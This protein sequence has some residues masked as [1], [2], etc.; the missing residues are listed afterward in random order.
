MAL[1]PIT[2][3]ARAA[4]TGPRPRTRSSATTSALA[5][6]GSGNRTVAE[7]GGEGEQA[8]GVSGRVLPEEYRAG[9]DAYFNRIEGQRP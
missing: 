6:V 1:E 3:R 7:A 5:L 4:R 8:T 9:L 2:V